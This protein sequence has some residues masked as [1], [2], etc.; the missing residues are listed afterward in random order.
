MNLLVVPNKGILYN[1]EKAKKNE[2]ETKHKTLLRLEE[3]RK[4]KRSKRAYLPVQ[5]IVSNLVEFA[6]SM[7][8]FLRH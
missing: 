3:N 8:D 7:F 4:K 1:E 5:K 6:I 2:Q